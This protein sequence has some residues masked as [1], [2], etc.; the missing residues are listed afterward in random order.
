DSAQCQVYRGAGTEHPLS[1]QAVAETKGLIASFEDKPIHALYTSTC[2][3][4]TEDGSAIFP[5]E[6]GPYLKGVPCYPEAEAESRTV[7]GNAWLGSVILEDGTRVNEEVQLL[8]LHG[9]VGK[10][11]LDRAWLLASCKGSDAE[12]WTAYTLGLL[13]KSADAK[14]LESDRVIM[15]EFASYLARSLVWGEQM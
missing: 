12:K 13:G 1:D 15:H 6:K 9:I 8:R 3:G 11:A 2:G 14:G 10:E 4:H 7:T 5:E